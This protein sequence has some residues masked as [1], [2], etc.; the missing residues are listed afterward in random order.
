MVTVGAGVLALA[1]GAAGQ[2][3]LVF[4]EVAKR[5][6][7]RNHLPA[8]E[9]LKLELPGVLARAFARIEL[10]TVCVY[11][12]PTSFQDAKTLKDVSTALVA[13]AEAQTTWKQWRTGTEPDPKAKDP[14]G[15]GIRA[16]KPETC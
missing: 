11:V 2:D 3:D 10:G 15:D 8:E 4:D 5:W 16:G 1:L 12:P 14:L 7:H 9:A 13:V 6:L